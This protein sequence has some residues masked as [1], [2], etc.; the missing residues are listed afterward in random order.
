MKKSEST[1]TNIPYLFVVVFLF[2]FSFVFSCLLLFLVVLPG[3]TDL[4][5]QPWDDLE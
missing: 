1:K 5:G 4:L 3:L 2:S